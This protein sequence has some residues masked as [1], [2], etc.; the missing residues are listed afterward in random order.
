VRL[1]ALGAVVLVGGCFTKPELIAR[2]GDAGVDAGG[3]ASGDAAASSFTPRLIRNAYWSEGNGSP[4]MSDTTFSIATAGINPGDL[5]LFIGN[6]DNGSNTIWGPVDGFSQLAQRY[7]GSDGQTY[8]IRYK[9]AGS[10]EPV[11]YV[12]S[13]GAVSSSH[14]AVI[15]LIAIAGA[16]PQFPP[17]GFTDAFETTGAANPAT[18]TAPGVTVTRP[19]SLVI[20]AGGA[21]WLGS[22]GSNTVHTPAGF[23]PLTTMGDKGGNGTIWEWTSQQIA[24]KE[25]L[26]AA[27][28]GEAL[29]SLQSNEGING[30][31]W[32]TLIAIAPAP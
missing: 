6:I 15:S 28:T 21:D 8:V 18:A 16:D 2:D 17:D 24:Y 22:N 3:D 14:A 7:Y 5:V 26:P 10:T 29:G 19:D 9:V 1:L 13:Y 27:T 32:A 12:G 30:I 25:H 4:G 31:G 23:T 20:Y 11:S